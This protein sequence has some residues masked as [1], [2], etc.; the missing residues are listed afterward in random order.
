MNHCFASSQR[1]LTGDILHEAIV[2]INQRRF[3]NI[4]EII[5]EGDNWQIHH[6]LGYNFGFSCWLRTKRKVEFR[7]EMGD[8]AH[9]VTAVFQS[10]IASK[11][12]GKC[13][14]E[15]VQDIWAPDMEKFP[16]F[17]AWWNLLHRS[18]VPDDLLS[19][20]DAQWERT[21]TKIPEILRKFVE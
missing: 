1:V 20:V 5:R 11:F 17:K 12:K 15:G 18:T 21:S 14:D 13:S 6:E 4:Y 8:W 7:P 3:D 9:W 10:E 19:F 2:E 16:T